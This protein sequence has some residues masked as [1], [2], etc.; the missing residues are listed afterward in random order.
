M[1]RVLAV[2]LV[3][4]QVWVPYAEAQTL[5]TDRQVFTVTAGGLVKINQSL[6]TV[7]KGVSVLSLFGRLVGPVTVGLALFELGSLF[8]DWYSATFTPSTAT[9][10]SGTWSVGDT[11]GSGL[12]MGEWSV[13]SCPWLGEPPAWSPS[14]NYLS[15]GSTVK[16]IKIYE[17]ARGCATGPAR[18]VLY[19]YAAPAMGAPSTDGTAVSVPSVPLAGPGDRNSLVAALE[20]LASEL[21]SG[22]VAGVPLPADVVGSPNY[23]GSAAFTDVVKA[24]DDAANVLRRGVPLTTGT[25][26]TAGPGY[27]VGNPTLPGNQTPTVPATG[28]GAS[29]DMGPTNTKLAEIKDT[30]DAM[31]NAAPSLAPENTCAECER[32]T[33]WVT[34]MQSWQSAASAAPIFLLISRLVWPGSGTVQREWSLGSWRGHDMVIDLSSSGIG[35]VI[36][37]VRFVVVGGAVIVA[38]MIIF[39]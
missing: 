4:L 39:G 8:W 26:V 30:L 35:S 2:V 7:A 18:R 28:A 21:R 20:G 6:Q 9:V 34:M 17:I 31:K 22:Q 23:K 27:Q 14:G 3:A 24:L 10:P 1:K 38:Y 16:G 25:D 37:V 5:L 32:K 33:T 19:V 11:S 36:T 12:Y 13:T 15:G 29:V